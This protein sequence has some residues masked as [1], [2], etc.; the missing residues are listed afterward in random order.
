MSLM[1]AS[2]PFVSSSGRN[3]SFVSEPLNVNERI[4][5]VV[6]IGYFSRLKTF[7]GFHES[8]CET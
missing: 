8:Y 7:E 1:F 2:S 4:F 5:A 6:E 3:S